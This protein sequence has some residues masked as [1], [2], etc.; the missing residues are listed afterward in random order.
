MLT[1][2]PTFAPPKRSILGLLLVLFLAGSFGIVGIFFAKD[3][4]YGLLLHRD[5]PHFHPHPGK[6]TRASVETEG[7]DTLR[8]TVYFEYVV[9]GT[10]YTADDRPTAM[11][12]KDGKLASRSLSAFT[13]G[14]PTLVYIDPKDPSR[15]TLQREVPLASSLRRGAFSLVFLIVCLVMLI[16]WWRTGK[17]QRV[18]AYAKH[19]EGQRQAEFE[20]RR[21]LRDRKK[22]GG[23]DEGRDA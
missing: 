8:P 20:T 3:A 14:T 11:V 17:R 6:V 23:V 15:A 1:P 2:P 19:V 16:T 7:Q 22:D 10:T 12:Y 4:L 5:A 9:D 21:K 13:V 18:L